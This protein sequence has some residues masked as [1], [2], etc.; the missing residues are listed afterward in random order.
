MEPIF[1][2]FE[3]SSLSKNSWPIEVGIAWFDSG[4]IIVESKLIRPVPAWS[5]EDWHPESE[6]IHGIPRTTLDEAEAA[7]D[8]AMWL[9]NK[10]QGQLV[11]SDA[12]EFDQRWCNRLM[13]TIG[14]APEI[15]IDDFDRVVWWA[16]SE[17]DGRIAPGRMHDVYGRL[18]A[19]KTIHRAGDDAAKLARAWLAGCR[20]SKG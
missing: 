1:I 17:L 14:G 16:F 19:E 11:V 3:A 2:D 6:E 10:L 15:K 4:D 12:P 9:R 18:T 20:E 8:V 7:A 5:M 13:E